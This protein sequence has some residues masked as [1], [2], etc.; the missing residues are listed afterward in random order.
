MYI[1]FSQ[2]MLDTCT[3]SQ[4]LA[5]NMRCQQWPGECYASNACSGGGIYASSSGVNLPCSVV[6][7][8]KAE[9]G[10]GGLSRSSGG[11]SAR[12]GVLAPLVPS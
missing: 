10:G 8:N 12:P 1:T 4:N 9:K 11:T 7:Q 2:V 5:G 3:V 6:I